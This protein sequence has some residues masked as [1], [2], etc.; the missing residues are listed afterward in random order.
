[1][2]LDIN[3]GM[4]LVRFVNRE[5][6]AR[7][8]VLTIKIVGRENSSTGDSYI[9]TLDCKDGGHSLPYREINPRNDW[10]TVWLNQPQINKLENNLKERYVFFLSVPVFRQQGNCT[11]SE[12]SVV[13]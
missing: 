6:E 5:G 7:F 8:L 2:E 10:L 4:K 13:H 1:M 11:Y 12:L 3:G 9:R